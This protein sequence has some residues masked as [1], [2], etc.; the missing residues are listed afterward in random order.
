MSAP[1]SQSR[2]LTPSTRPELWTCP[3]GTSSPLCYAARCSTA[4]E[5]GPALSFLMG[6]RMAKAAF[7]TA[8]L[9]A[10]LRGA[11]VRLADHLASLSRTGEKPR[12][13]V[14]AGVAVGLAASMSELLDEVAE[15]TSEGYGRVKLKIRPGW[16]EEPL[17]AVRRAWPD[18]VIFA[19]ANGSYSRL[20]FMDACLRLAP[21]GR[22]R[23]GLHRATFRR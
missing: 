9:D 6:H 2:P 20:P 7:E 17:A 19:D 3:K 12:D 13:T 16:D 14:M 11:G 21:P 10:Q 23:P 1:H 15:R 4:E 18:L 5:V 8:L 22:D